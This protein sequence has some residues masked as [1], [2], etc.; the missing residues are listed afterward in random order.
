M[1]CLAARCYNVMFCI[2]VYLSVITVFLLVF[3][4]IIQCKNTYNN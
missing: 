4:L 1:R 2:L 3:V